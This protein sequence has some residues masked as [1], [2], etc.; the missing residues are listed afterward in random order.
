VPIQIKLRQLY[1]L[2]DD[3]SRAAYVDVSVVHTAMSIFI[4]FGLLWRPALSVVFECFRFVRTHAG[5]CVRLPNAIRWEL[6]TMRDVLGFLC[7]SLSMTFVPVVLAQDAAGPQTGTG[8]DTLRYGA[9][10]IA[11][12]TPPLAEVDAVIDSLETIGRAGLL[13]TIGVGPPVT[14]PILGKD[15]DIPLIQRTVV[16]KTWISCAVAWERLLARRW[17]FPLGICEGELRATAVWSRILPRMDLH[18]FEV[19][20]QGAV[21]GALPRSV[22]ALELTLLREVEHGLRGDRRVQSEEHLNTHVGSAG[23]RRHAFGRAWQAPAARFCWLEEKR[24]CS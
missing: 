8:D 3:L 11:A 10:R 18:G 15:E 7:V 14:I 2:L 9:W 17:Q 5:R 12:G 13:P 16:P 21:G 6:I 4:W 24:V 1:E 23:R 22:F 20:G 19:L